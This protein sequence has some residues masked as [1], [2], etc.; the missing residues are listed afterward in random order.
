MHIWVFSR[1]T[2]PWRSTVI[3]LSVRPIHMSEFIL[4]PA[5]AQMLGT[6]S[7][8]AGRVVKEPKVAS[9]LRR[10][11]T[12]VGSPMDVSQTHATSSSGV[13]RVLDKEACCLIRF[14]VRKMKVVK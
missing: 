5:W 3:S 12:I 7:L 8:N 2:H 13:S 1:S 14:S 4:E 6:G 11:I 9:G 10:V